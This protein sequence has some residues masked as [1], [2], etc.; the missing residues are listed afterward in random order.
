MQHLYLGA[1]FRV[2]ET[3]FRLFQVLNIQ[4]RIEYHAVILH[5]LRWDVDVVLHMINLVVS[6]LIG[7][8]A[9][10][11]LGRLPLWIET[12]TQQISRKSWALNDLL[13]HRKPVFCLKVAILFERFAP[14]WRWWTSRLVSQALR[15]PIH[16]PKKCVILFKL[17]TSLF[18][19]YEAIIGGHVLR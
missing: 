7:A 15:Q 19:S 9:R 18:F 13:L 6:Y 17:N 8:T 2:F 16:Q 4:A 14:N 11:L 10:N 12:Q 5:I 3:A 1:D